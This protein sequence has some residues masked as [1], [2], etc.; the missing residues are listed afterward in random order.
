MCPRR[1]GFTCLAEFRVDPERCFVSG[2]TERLGL[3]SDKEAEAHEFP[4]IRRCRLTPIQANGVQNAKEPIAV[5]TDLPGQTLS[6]FS[7]PTNLRVL[8]EGS[9]KEPWLQMLLSGRDPPQLSADV[10]SKPELPA[11]VFEQLKR[12]LERRPS[13]FV[14]LP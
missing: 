8:K 1:K 9:V 3:C 14:P 12:Q 10:A 6:P 2:E 5:Q 11:I 13:P 4:R 7:P